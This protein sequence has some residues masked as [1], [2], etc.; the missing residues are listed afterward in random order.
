MIYTSVVLF[1]GFIIFG[2]SSFGGTV[3]LGILTS[4]TLL[5]AM[6]TNLTVLPSL[7]L[8]FDSSKYYKQ[9]HQQDFKPLIE[10]DSEFYQEAEDEEIDLSMISKRPGNHQPIDIQKSEDK[11]KADR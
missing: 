5:V 8:A 4:F 6:F 7:L 2:G 11:D 1:A 3:Y 10:H 9:Y